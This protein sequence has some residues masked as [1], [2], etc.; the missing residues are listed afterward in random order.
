MHSV[1]KLQSVVSY[2]L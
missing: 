2:S 1:L